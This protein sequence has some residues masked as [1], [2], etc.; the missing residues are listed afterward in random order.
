MK[1]LMFVLK[2]LWAQRKKYYIIYMEQVLI[3]IV[4]M[5]CAVSFAVMLEEY[6]RPG[7]L[8]VS[9]Q[10]AV[11]VRYSNQYTDQIFQNSINA[12]KTIGMK[13]REKEYVV[14]TVR[15]VDLA[16]YL[17]SDGFYMGDS[18][19][20]NDK[21]YGVKIKYAEKEAADLFNIRLT[22]GKWFDEDAL[23]DGSCPAI[24]TQ[25]LA[26]SL[27]QGNRREVIGQK[28][29][30]RNRECT[31]I[32]V[33]AGLKQSTFDFSP[34][35][36]VFPHKY[37]FGMGTPTT[38]VKIEEGHEQ[39]FYHDFM[40]EYEKIAQSMGLGEDYIPCVLDMNAM[41]RNDRF[42]ELFGIT[43]QATPTL[44]F[45]LFA[46]LGTFSLFWMQSKKRAKEYALQIAIGLAPRRLVGNIVCESVLLS[47]FAVI[48][49]II[50]ACFIY[51]WTWVHVAAIAC[52]VL[53]MVLFAVFSAWYPAYKVSRINPA[54]VLHYE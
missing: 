54:E 39:D 5:I 19:S 42:D 1:R 12:A 16:P 18:L 47:L 41:K 37:Y 35:A 8:D 27:A 7:L 43:A 14:G 29:H 10:K 53:I 17:R 22:K 23:P 3:T 51:E 45:I 28:F 48:P 2:M 26:D 36:V 46:F 34:Q 33:V 44:F 13:M 25:Q 32:G 49:A 4:L 24:I 15:E 52:T 11:S 30:Y 20:I 6:L 50:I 31:I 40:Q 38:I 9:N 21:K